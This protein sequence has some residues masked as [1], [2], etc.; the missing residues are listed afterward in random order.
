MKNILRLTLQKLLGYDNYLFWFSVF[1]I[2]R[3]HN[4]RHEREF[5]EFIN[6]LPNEGAI[7]DIGANIGVMT[8]AMAQKCPNARVFAFEPMPNNV[9]GIKRILAHYKLQN[10]KL[11]EN[12]LGDKAGSLEMVLP[13]IGN[14][15]MQGLS[16]VVKPGDDSAWNKGEF[17]TV[18]VLRLDDMPEL[19]ALP[20]ITAIKIDVENFEYFVFK[21]GENL[22]RKHKPKIYCELW[23]NEQRDNTL[24]FM[25]SLGYTVNIF[26]GTRLV[27]FTNQNEVNFFLI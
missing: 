20:K 12:A 2:K 25:R 22:L 19:I 1:T 4:N 18:P 3:L 17:F 13:V 15:K 16:H 23:Q 24:D 11:F 9:K 27:P 14:M 6:M 5:L 21:G 10:V 26:D 7:L 8:V